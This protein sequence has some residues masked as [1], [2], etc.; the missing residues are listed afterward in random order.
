MKKS[1]L[2]LAAILSLSASAAEVGLFGSRSMN[3]SDVNGAGVS[4]TQQIYG[5]VKATAFIDR[6]VNRSV[7]VNRLG[8]GLSYDFA[9]IGPVTL[10]TQAGVNRLVTT[11][12]PSGYAVVGGF[13]AEYAFTKDV[14]LVAAVLNQRGQQRVAGFNGNSVNVGLR[15]GF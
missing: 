10:N 1:M 9:K 12:K 3:G 4:L 13:G 2:A 8:V 6:T 15:Y 5:P 14:S 7:D 11:G